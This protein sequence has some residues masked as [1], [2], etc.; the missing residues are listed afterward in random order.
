[1][2]SAF[3]VIKSRLSG[4][5]GTKGGGGVALTRGAVQF[6]DWLIEQP[7]DAIIIITIEWE[8]VHVTHGRV[9]DD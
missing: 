7:R 6:S 4:Q 2:I 9:S 5:Q 1:M 3:S 8:E